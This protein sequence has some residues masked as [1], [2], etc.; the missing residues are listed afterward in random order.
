M[1]N[2][3]YDPNNPYPQQP[4]ASY[5]SSGLY[6]PPGPYTQYPGPQFTPH[7][8]GLPPMMSQQPVKP[9]KKKGKALW[10]IL[11]II[12]VVVLCIAL[13][14]AG[15]SSTTTTATTTSNTTDIGN[16]QPKPTQPPAAP[17][18]WQT[19]HTYTGN[20]DKQ[21][22]TFTVGNDWKIQWKCQA[23]DAPLFV[24]IYNADTNEMT[25]W[26]AVSTSCKKTPTTGETAEHGGGNLYLK[27]ISGI[28]WTIT[29]QEQK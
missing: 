5:P 17:K 1:N 13:A 26:S 29:I 12:G 8:P 2:P 14:N 20:G 6:P 4:P 23:D 18:T 21:T 7:P 19:I 24:E 11:G 22:E 15:K 3:P 25:D 10:F 9:P 16:S 27:I 28:D